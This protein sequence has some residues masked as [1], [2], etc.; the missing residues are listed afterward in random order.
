M[1]WLPRCH[2]EEQIT[3]QRNGKIGKGKGKGKRR[4]WIEAANPWEVGV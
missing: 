1:K 2:G 3:I 4:G